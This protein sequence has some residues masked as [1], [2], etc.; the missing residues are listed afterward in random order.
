MA[1]RK[2]ETKEEIKTVEKKDV[3]VNVY[4]VRPEALV[5]GYIATIDGAVVSIPA[6]QT[7]VSGLTDEQVRQMKI[8][9]VI[10]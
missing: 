2:Q 3:K 6:G 5:T 7:E 4:Q 8:A 9:K 1:K 10:Y